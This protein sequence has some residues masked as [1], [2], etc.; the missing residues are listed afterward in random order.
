MTEAGLIPAGFPHKQPAGSQPLTASHMD[1]LEPL[2]SAPERGLGDAG[3]SA[4]AACQQQQADTKSHVQH[5]AVSASREAACRN[6]A[7]Q[8]S[9]GDSA[10]S[11]A[12][13]LAQ[14]QNGPGN[15]AFTG[16][17]HDRLKSMPGI[18]AGP[19]ASAHAAPPQQQAQGSTR[20]GISDI[21]LAAELA[22]QAEEEMRSDMARQEQHE[23][24]D[25]DRASADPLG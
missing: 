8:R 10:K 18:P 3:S 25:E 2:R 13:E 21:D 19:A 20:A 5:S 4:P 1:A 12:Q 7:A 14:E 9:D 16:L 11:T 22:A 17:V 23:P 24:P 15:V 6:P